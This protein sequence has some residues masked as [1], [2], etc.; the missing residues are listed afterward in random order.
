MKNFIVHDKDGKILR[1]GVCQDVDFDF[2]AHKDEFIM[3][4][5]ANGATQK[6]IDRGKSKRIVNKTVKEMQI[7]EPKLVEIPEE[8]KPAHITNEQWQNVL[9]RIDDLEKK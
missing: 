9:K 4:G 3:E 8:Q 5:T 2:Q 7:E 1:T 6:I